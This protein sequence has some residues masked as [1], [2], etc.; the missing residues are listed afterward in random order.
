MVRVRECVI[1]A[2]ALGLV[3]LLS[4]AGGCG[5]ASN[6][7]QGDDAGDN[8]GSGGGSG[9]STSGGSSGAS[10]SSGSSSGSIFNNPS[11]DAAAA[12]CSGGG[13]GC[14]V[15]PN[16][17][18]SITGTVYDPAGANPLYNV[19]V[20][21]PNDPKGALTPIKKGTN[22]CS[23]CDVSIGDYVTAT[24]SRAD[25]TFTLTG[26]PAT[27]H[28]P[29]V[30]QIGKWRREVFLSQVKACT[31]NVLPGSS[32]TR[33]PAKRSEGDIPQM[34]LVTGGADNLGC[35]LEG[36]GLDPS[37]YGKPGGGGRL[38]I[39]QGLPIGANILGIAL[40]RS[41]PGLTGGGAGD[42]TTD[43]ANCVWNSKAN[44]EKYDI[45][46]LSCEGNAFDPDDD[47]GDGGR[48]G[49]G[50]RGGMSNKTPTA[51]Q[52]LH[53]W[54]NEGGK[55]FATHYHYTWFRNS[56][57]PDFQAVANWLGSSG[58]QGG[59]APYDIDTSFPKGKVLDQWLGTVKALTGTQITLNNVANSVSTVNAT[60][61]RWIYDPTN[62]YVKYL[63]FVTPIGGIPVTSTDGGELPAQYCGKAVFS[64]LHAGGSPMGDIPGNCSGPPLTA[65]LKA[66]EFLFFDLSACVS[67]DNQPPPP[68][69]QPAK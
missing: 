53:D 59:N 46:L 61:Q 52:A 3:V 62:S 42:C 58:A 14:Y 44:F 4:S 22:T 43:N 48:G 41:A 39:Y 20:F 68:P 12:A 1:A 13:L 31:N 6:N 11:D 15:P 21:I 26:V 34:A 57:Q 33:L 29:L 23:S 25:G 54:L 5:S 28:V 64:D 55:V 60:A 66:L 10:G 24:T 16:C 45:V 38:D 67:V 51:K 32:L 35:F 69:P 8:G 49:G 18:T 56:P 63:S 65:Q 50:G 17:T 9:G 37:E 19:V 30:V 7:F 27:T 2:W 47:G 36:V 40:G